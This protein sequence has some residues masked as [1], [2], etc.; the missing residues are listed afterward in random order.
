MCPSSFRPSMPSQ[1]DNIKGLE[2]LVLRGLCA[3]L[4]G[5]EDYVKCVDALRTYSWQDAEH[6]LV[7]EA[8]GRIRFLPM[9]LRRGELAAEVTRMGF[10]DI[11]CSAYL[12][13]KSITAEELR[14]LIRQ[15][16]ALGQ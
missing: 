5:K 10:P 6:R 1:E 8:L 7:Y 15:I 14:E 12:E 11:D 9:A 16:Q 3:Y 2:R 13:G 4:S